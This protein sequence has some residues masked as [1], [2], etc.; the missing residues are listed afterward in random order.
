MFFICFTF[1]STSHEFIYIIMYTDAPFDTIKGPILLSLPQKTPY[2]P[3]SLSP[4]HPPHVSALIGGK[5][6]G[7]VHTATFVLILK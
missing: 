5:P 1:C 7:D 6:G 3:P 2:S 4:P